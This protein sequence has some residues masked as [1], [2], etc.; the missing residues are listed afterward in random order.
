[1]S[2]EL[3]TNNDFGPARKIFDAYSL[4]SRLSEDKQEI[5]ADLIIRYIED[6]GWGLSEQARR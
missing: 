1:M 6:Q 3:D 5:L 4:I 2:D